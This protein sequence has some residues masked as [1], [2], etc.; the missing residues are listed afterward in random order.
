MSECISSVLSG[1]KM[2]F[3]G[4]CPVWC[5]FHWIHVSY[6]LV[7]NGTAPWCWMWFWCL[8]W[9]SFENDSQ[10]LTYF[11]FSC[12]CSLIIVISYSLYL[13]LLKHPTL[14]FSIL[15]FQCP[16]YP[17]LR[18]SLCTLVGLLWVRSWVGLSRGWSRGSIGK[19]WLSQCLI[20]DPS[21]ACPATLGLHVSTSVPH[22]AR[23]LL[24]EEMVSTAHS[25]LPIKR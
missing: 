24:W 14:S 18:L 21:V 9:S 6:T 20:N 5:V 12:G 19:R 10:H 1:R 23:A 11:I 8:L 2:W 4:V 16:F 25:R 15:P 7:G 13:C 3:G 17:P 22:G